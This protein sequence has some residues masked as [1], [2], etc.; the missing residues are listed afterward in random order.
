MCGIVGIVGNPPEPA[1][2]ERM[3]RRLTHRGP[4]HQQVWRA[5]G[6]HLGHTRLAILDLSPAGNQPMTYGDFTLTYNGE[7]YNFKELRQQLEGPF[8]S[9]GDTEV[10]LHLYARDGARCIDQ[11]RGMFAFAIWDARRQRLFAA[12]DRLGIKPF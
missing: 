7:I 4:D 5:P 11:L 3:T 6:V 10:L 9:D 8:H 2:I 12:R 1:V